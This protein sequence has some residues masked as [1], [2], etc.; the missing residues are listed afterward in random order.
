MKENPKIRSFARR[1]TWRIALSQFIVMALVSWLIYSFAKM[2]FTIEE[3]DLYKSYLWTAKANVRQIVLEVTASTGNR[4]NEIEEHISDPDKMAAIMKEV[5][6]QNPHIRSC[7]ISFVADYYPQKG[8]WYC[9]YAVKVE[10]SQIEQRFIG[11][12]HNDYL[13]AEWFTEALQADSSYW[14]K[15]FFDSTD[16]ITPLVSYMIP[17]HDKQGRTVAVL[18]AD[19]SLKWLSGARITGINYNGETHVYVSSDPDEESINSVG[20]NWVDKKWRLSA[21][22]FIIDSNGT[23]LAHPDSSYVI[24]ENY[25]NHAKETSDSLADHIGRQMVAGK[26]STTFAYP[27]PI[28]FFDMEFGSTAYVFYEPIE[29]TNWSMASV[30]P[31]IAIDFIAIAIAVIL[32]IFIGLAMLVTR[33]AGRII[34]KRTARPL[35]KLAQSANEVAKGNFNAPLPIIKHND[36]IRLLRD[37]FEGMQHSLKDYIEELKQTTASKAAIENELKVAHDIQMSMLPKTFPPYPERDD[38]DIYGKLTPA[39]EVGGDL[40]DFYIRDEKLFFCI[41]DV[42]GK[43]IPASLVM[44]MVRS[45]FRN[46]SLHVSEPNMIV[47]ALNAAVA[48]GNETNMFV[49]L[50]LGVFDLH[51]GILQYCNAGHNSPLLMGKDVRILACDSNLP[52]GVISDW[53]FS[54]QEIQLEPQTTIFLYTDGLN[55]AEDSLHGLFGE[56]RIIRV[57]ESQLVDGPIMPATI[58]SRMEEAVHRFVDDA[59]Q[60]DDLTMLAIKYTKDNEE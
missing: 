34:I 22:N 59:E 17:I 13:K 5:V 15:P 33:I 41:G 42:S 51:T 32:L 37:S 18:G 21:T 10:G 27:R 3:T 28:K 6:T 53:A 35:K 50:F 8:H 1:L 60:S 39:K 56:E 19:L 49:T 11:D 7:G 14:S 20:L 52:I 30:V 38:V 24:H 31:G 48:D 47:K 40:F 12:K 36:E 9:P 44:A 23:F 25:F 55:E 26:R 2:M 57:A 4:V 58:V 45:L 29:N 43:G 16:S 54:R 46:V